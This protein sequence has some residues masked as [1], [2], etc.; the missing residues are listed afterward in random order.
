MEEEG[1][2]SQKSDSPYMTAGI[3]SVF[4]MFLLYMCVGGLCLCGNK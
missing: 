1:D 4:H 3:S 2:T